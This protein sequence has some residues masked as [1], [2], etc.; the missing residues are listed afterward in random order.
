MDLSP[1]RRAVVAIG[2]GRFGA[3]CPAAL[4]APK[5]C[6]GLSFFALVTFA[7]KVNEDVLLGA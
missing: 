2:F 4:S 1:E 7:L 5:S 6:V 3:A